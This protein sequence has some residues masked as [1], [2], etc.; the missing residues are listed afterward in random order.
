MDLRIIMENA[1]SDY[2]V[3]LG[4]VIYMLSST[5]VQH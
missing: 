5:L 1:P 2:S 3:N 4:T